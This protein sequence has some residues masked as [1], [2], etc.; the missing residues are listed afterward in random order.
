[1]KLLVLGGGAQGSAAAF[2]LLRTE[3]VE[4]VVLADH[5]AAEVA[6]FLKPQ[7]GG[8][9]RLVRLDAEDRD[10]VL[11]VMDG[12]D[13]TLCALPYFFGFPMAEAAVEAGTHYCDLG[14]N[15]EIVERQRTLDGA[16]R[17]KGL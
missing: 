6:A 3:G 7:L 13:G 8:R 16:A 1:M 4:E 2:D 12:V 11:R 9:L 15:T 5:Q 17:A 10:A 14:G